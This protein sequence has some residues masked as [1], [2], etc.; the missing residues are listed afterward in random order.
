[1]V[2]MYDLPLSEL[3]EFLGKYDH[4]TIGMSRDWGI[5]MRFTPIWYYEARSRVPKFL[6]TAIENALN[7]GDENIVSLMAI[8]SY[9]KKVEGPLPKHNYEIYRFYDEREVRHVPSFEHVVR[10]GNTPIFTEDEYENYKVNT[11]APVINSHVPFEWSDVRYII[12]Q[13]KSEVD[14]M[15]ET[16]DNLGCDNRHIGVFCED[17]IIHDVIGYHHNVGLSSPSTS[18]AICSSDKRL[19]QLFM[20]KLNELM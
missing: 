5:K 17:E 15:L 18:S 9:M 19:V 16:L 14:K 2:S 4:Y 3:S 20:N 10:G 8:L 1:M 11:G 7:K 6:K 12:V 13:E